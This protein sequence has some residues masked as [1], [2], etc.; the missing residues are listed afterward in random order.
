M[1][2]SPPY[3]P[4]PEGPP[5]PEGQPPY[6]PYQ[7]PH[8]PAQSQWTTPPPP[9][10]PGD[11]PIHGRRVAQGIGIAIG[12]HLVSIAL[13]VAVLLLT[14]NSSSQVSIWSIVSLGAQLLVFVGCLVFGILG[15][16][17]GDRG[18]GLG[19]LIGWAVGVIVLPVIGAGVC[20]AVLNAQGTT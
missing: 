17:R 1:T 15:L 7:P 6:E 8:G 16:T 19:L 18:R 13:S 20:I 3:E 14:R 2:Q 10:M 5:P 4:P 9:R 12:A 11:R